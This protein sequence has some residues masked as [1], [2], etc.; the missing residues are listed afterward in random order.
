M[1]AGPAGLSYIQAEDAFGRH[2]HQ[3]LRLGVTAFPPT[4]QA[5]FPLD[6]KD[7]VETAH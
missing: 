3:P 4:I 6:A 2:T 7:H 1:C 5:S